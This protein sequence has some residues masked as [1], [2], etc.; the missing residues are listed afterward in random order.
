[1]YIACIPIYIRGIAIYM[2]CIAAELHIFSICM[3]CSI[4]ETAGIATGK[5]LNPVEK[6]TFSLWIKKDIPVFQELTMK[7]LWI[8]LL[9]AFFLHDNQAIT[10]NYP[11]TNGYA[12]SSFF[13]AG[14]NQ[15]LSNM[16]RVSVKFSS[17]RMSVAQ[18][19][20]Y[21]NH[22]VASMTGNPTFP[23]PH[24][25][26]A[27]ITAAINALVS[28]QNA[29]LSGGPAQTSLM[30]EKK[31]ALIALLK[32]EVNYVETVANDPAVT[33]ESRATIVLSAGMEVAQTPTHQPRT[34]E[35]K[36]GQLSGSVELRAPGIRGNG[37]HVWEYVLEPAASNVWLQG[38]ITTKAELELSNLQPGSK[39]SFRHRVVTPKEQGEW[40]NP[41]TIMVV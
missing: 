28:A 40:D 27:A 32:L 2:N 6:T 13:L 31:D 5:V 3:A 1:M 22:M 41:I 23:Q 37:S 35:V 11:F 4:I 19:I 8:I 9:I 29:A 25:T 21:S 33:D 10:L 20:E 26:L 36:P 30:H 18:L 7:F 39:Y 14:L 15:N 16:K 24:P 12:K 38:G 17:N 34:F